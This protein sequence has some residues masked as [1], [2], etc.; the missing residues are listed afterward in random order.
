MRVPCC[1]A[2]WKRGY[3]SYADAQEALRRVRRRR[4]KSGSRE[5]KAYRCP[6]CG[7][8]HLTSKRSRKLLDGRPR[9]ELL[10]EEEAM[11]GV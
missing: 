8:W 3:G 11:D 6:H 4:R 1:V 10:L 7:H 2:S 9:R 5:N